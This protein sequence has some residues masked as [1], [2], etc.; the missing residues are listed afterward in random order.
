MLFVAVGYLWTLLAVCVE[1]L[2]LGH[3]YDEY[4]VL[5]EN[6]LWQKWYQSH[7]NRRNA[8]LD[9]RVIFI[10][11]FEVFAKTNYSNLSPLFLI[12]MVIYSRLL[13]FL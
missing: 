8:S 13:L 1:Q 12:L 5:A 2:I 4:L 9:R 3:A 10:I 11:L 6:Q 7:V